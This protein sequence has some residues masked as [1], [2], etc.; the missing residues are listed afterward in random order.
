MHA[1]ECASSFT[2]DQWNAV[3]RQCVN[4]FNAKGWPIALWKNASTFQRMGYTFVPQIPFFKGLNEMV[5]TQSGGDSI[6]SILAM[7]IDV[8]TLGVRPRIRSIDALLLL[9]SGKFAFLGSF[10]CV[11]AMIDGT[12]FCE[13]L[14]NVVVASSLLDVEAKAT[15]FIEANQTPYNKSADKIQ[16][17]TKDMPW[18]VRGE[19]SM[20]NVLLEDLCVVFPT[21]VIDFCMFLEGNESVILASEALDL[22]FWKSGFWN[23]M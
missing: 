13:M 11:N 7:S 5:A 21:L 15:K 1:P 20:A 6:A 4:V 2:M 12:R 8:G 10:D 18:C 23:G 16:N 19:A 3:W 14:V 22:R 17:Y 9:R